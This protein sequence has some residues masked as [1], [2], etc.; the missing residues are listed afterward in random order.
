MTYGSNGRILRPD[1]RQDKVTGNL[2]LAANPS[3]NSANYL[4]LFIPGSACF[5]MPMR[6]SNYTVMYCEVDMRALVKSVMLIYM[7]IEVRTWR[8]QS[9][10]ISQT[11]RSKRG[12]TDWSQIG[13]WYPCDRGEK[14]V[15]L[16]SFLPI[17][18]IERSYTFFIPDIHKNK[19]EISRGQSKIGWGLNAMH[20]VLTCDW[21]CTLAWYYIIY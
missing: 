11:G 2:F 10:N 18:R 19:M 17:S 3:L 15:L 13:N 6:G 9:Y 21:Y 20:M 14:F 1:L 4:E 7:A 16:I 5:T 8:E 12:R